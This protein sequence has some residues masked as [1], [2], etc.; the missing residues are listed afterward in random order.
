MS[1]AFEIIP[2]IDLIEGKCVRLSQ[3]DYGRK[4]IYNENPL[5]VALQYEDAGLQRLHLVDLD[6]AKKGEVA[7]FKVLEKIASRTQLTIDFGGGIKTTAAL[8]N[9]F[10]AGA[11]MASIGSIALK[12]KELFYSWLIGFGAERFLLGA[13]V[14]EEK[15]AVHGWLENTDVSV[16]DFIR[17]N[18]SRGVNKVFCT[19]IAKDGLLQGPSLDLYKKLLKEIKD[20]QLIASGGVANAG[21]VEKIQ[22]S[23]CT[24]VIIGKA[25]YEG[26][27]SL[28]ELSRFNERNKAC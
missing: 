2:A 6:G 1:A 28:Q 16:F 12:D 21:D 26:K 11:A 4:T 27:I 13:D 22:E 3:G 23:G 8:K 9:V 10:D 24:G 5:E 18:K 7:N 17:E 14:K 19:D 20:L 25:I 15:I